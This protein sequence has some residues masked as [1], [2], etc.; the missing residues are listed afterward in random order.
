MNPIYSEWKRVFSMAMYKNKQIS[1][2]E[3]TFTKDFV[4]DTRGDLYPIIQKSEDC[5]E[6]VMF[7]RYTVTDGSVKRLF[8][9]FFPYASY[10]VTAS[11]TGS[12]GFTFHTPDADAEV[13]VCGGKLFY[14]CKEHTEEK[15]LPHY[16]T[17]EITLIVTCRPGAFDIYFKHNEKSEFFC[18]V[19]EEAFAD[20]N[21]ESLFMSSQVLLSVSGNV[22]VSEVLSYLDNHIS[23]ADI[24]VIKYENGEVMQENG[25]VYLT[26][27]VRMQVNGF[28]GI[29]SWVPGTSEIELCG[30]IFFDCGD[31]KWRNYLASSI[32]YHRENKEWMLWTSAFEHGHILAYSHFEGDPRFGVNVIDVTSMP[33]AK[34]GDKRTDFVGFRGDEDPDFF[35]DKERDIWTLAICRLAEDNGGYQYMFF[36]SKDPFVGY[37][38]IGLAERGGETGGSFARVEGELFFTCGNSFQRRSEYR[39]YDKDGMKL[40]HFDFPDG[41]FRGWGTLIPV[42]AGSRIRYYWLTFDRHNGSD[43]NWSYGNLYCFEAEK[44]TKN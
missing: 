40:A 25:K 31:G 33:A 9:R 18:T 42:K 4:T 21:L 19:D 7:N 14:A 6:A 2:G 22:T 41:G 34:D 44:L 39:I 5:D 30:A 13:S 12:F 29:Y 37:Q 10:E 3:M 16:L 36:E 20:S 38:Y 1:M 28:Q 43:Y 24:K 32:I 15:E 17:K 8:C 35:Y 23:I 27:S 11:G 26:A